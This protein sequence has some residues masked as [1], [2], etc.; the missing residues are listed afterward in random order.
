MRVF[1]AS[2]QEG[3]FIHPSRSVHPWPGFLQALSLHE[4]SVAHSC[5][6]LAEEWRCVWVS[7]TVPKF[8]R[9]EVLIKA[10]WKDWI[11]VG[12]APSASGPGRIPENRRDHSIEKT[13]SLIGTR[14]V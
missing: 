3:V 10:H 7:H 9:P 14:D 8:F 2:P 6:S 11:L 12:N 5:P 4:P 13:D 1:V